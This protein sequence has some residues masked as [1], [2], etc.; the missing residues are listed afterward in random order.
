MAKLRSTF[1]NMVIVLTV[2]AAL[3]GTALGYTHQLTEQ[4]IQLAQ[5]AKQEASIRKVAPAFDN[6]PAEEKIVRTLDDNSTIYIYPAKQ[7][8]EWVGAAVESFS[9]N[10]FGGQ[11]DIMVGFEK[12]G[13]IRDYTVLKHTET[14][15]LGSKMETWFH[16]DKN[17][18]SVIGKNPAS[19]R[20]SVSKDGG[21]IDAIT[22]ATISSRA[23]LEAIQKAYNAYMNQ[24][25]DA[26]S[27]ASPV[28]K[29]NPDDESPKEEASSHE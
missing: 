20:M 13:T 2:T 24:N 23:F 1:P 5:K 19:V 28:V 22:A 26:V 21:D 12:D 14:P 25:N 16:Q 15:G 11:I 29:E 6:A 3:A 8:G 9:K 7:G 17:R 27:G 18:Q 10:G 4:P